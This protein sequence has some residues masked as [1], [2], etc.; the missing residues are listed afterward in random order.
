MNSEFTID[1]LAKNIFAKPADSFRYL[2]KDTPRTYANSEFRNVSRAFSCIGKRT[3]TALRIRKLQK[4]EIGDIEF[5][6]LWKDE[7]F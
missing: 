4:S 3:L 1:G 7:F 6:Q 2:L 5:R